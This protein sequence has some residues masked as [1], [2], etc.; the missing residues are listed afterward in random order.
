LNLGSGHGI[1][2]LLIAKN[3]NCEITAVEFS[4]KRIERCNYLKKKYGVKS[5]Q[6]VHADINIYLDNLNNEY[7]IIMAFEVLEHL[8]KPSEVI[9]KCKK[10][11]SEV[12][13]GTVPIQPNCKQKQHISSFDTIGQ[14]KEILGCNV[15]DQ[16]VIPLR[17]PECI[18]F[19][20]KQA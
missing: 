18:S 17:L 5:V 9:L 3:Y 14:A 12:F 7:D 11:S 1:L 16:S 20:Y 15:Y 2:D 4:N 6:F 13:F 19:Y 10:Y 8:H